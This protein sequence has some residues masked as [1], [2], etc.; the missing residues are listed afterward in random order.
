MRKS[1]QI[2]AAFAIGGVIGGFMSLTV[3]TGLTQRL[4]R[5][6]INRLNRELAYWERII[7][8]LSQGSRIQSLSE[9]N[10]EQS[11]SLEQTS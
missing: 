2:A 1:I 7:Q 4:E 6:E 10:G 11:S 5:Q 3:S 9:R 8:G